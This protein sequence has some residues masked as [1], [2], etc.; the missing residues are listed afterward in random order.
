VSKSDVSALE[1]AVEQVNIAAEM[2]NLD[3]GICDVLKK[4]TR[5]LIVSVPIKRDNG[6]INVFT[7][8]RVQHNKARGPYKGG[9]RYHPTVTLDEV[10]ALAMW[11]TWK[12]AIVDIPYGGAKGGVRCNPK[13]LSISELERLTRRYATMILN[14][15]GPY[16]DVPAPDVY[17]DS[18]TMA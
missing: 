14:F 17:T 5:A 15:I 16:Q 13:E 8:Y 10:T 3:S 7:G 18:Q 6:E 11:M 2:L 1:V 4:P 12:C 9:I